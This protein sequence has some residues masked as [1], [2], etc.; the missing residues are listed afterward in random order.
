MKQDSGTAMSLFASV[1]E[2]SF[3]CDVFAEI[4]DHSDNYLIPPIHIHSEK[5][6][7]IAPQF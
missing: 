2:K 6:F 5:D 7:N 4:E 1:E 3:V